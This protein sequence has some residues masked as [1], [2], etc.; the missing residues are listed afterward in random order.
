MQRLLRAVYRKRSN[1]QVYDRR[2][3]GPEQWV[4]PIGEFSCVIFHRRNR[5]NGQNW[6][7]HACNN[8]PSNRRPVGCTGF[9]P[10]CRR[11]NQVTRSENNAKS[12]NPMITVSFFIVYLS[13]HSNNVSAFIF[14]KTKSEKLAQ[15][16][17]QQSKNSLARIVVPVNMIRHKLPG[18]HDWYRTC[19]RL[20]NENKSN[21][22]CSMTRISGCFSQGV[23]LFTLPS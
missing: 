9:N 3:H 4:N 13:L 1:S 20:G 7:P 11:I 23:T 5:R 16:Y 12:I 2:K 22:N 18:L 8:K 6:Q 10:Q 17:S 15:K 21:S 14:N 19:S